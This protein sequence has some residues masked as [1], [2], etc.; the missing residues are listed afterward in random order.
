MEEC[1]LGHHLLAERVKSTRLPFRFRTFSTTLPAPNSY[2]MVP[3]TRIKTLQS[4]KS[5]ACRVLVSSDHVEGGGS[6]H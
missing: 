3:Q 6:T 1:L 2:G 4:E 5:K